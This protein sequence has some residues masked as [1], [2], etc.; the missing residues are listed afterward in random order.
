MKEI[1]RKKI[2]AFLKKNGRKPISY[3]ELISKC[4]AHKQKDIFDDVIAEL[5]GQ[6]FIL[7][8][9]NGYVSVK[10]IG[11]FPA[12]VSRINKTFGFI[13]RSDD[14]TEVFIPG[15]F[16]MAAMP[17]DI[18]IARLIPSRTGKPEGEIVSIVKEQKAR[19]TGVIVED[20]G[21]IAILPDSIVKTPIE[22]VYTRHDDF[23]TGDKVIAEIVKR[24]KRH[25]EHKAKVVTSF[26]SA[27]RAEAC[28]E[29]VLMLNGITKE[30]PSQVL[31]EAVKVSEKGISENEINKRTD[32]R[33]QI[34]FTIDG[35]DTKDIDDAV[36]IKKFEDFYELGVHIADVSYYVKPRSELDKEAF[37][38]GTSV[39]YADKV[40]PMLPK[41]L[42]NGICSLNPNE[43]RLAFSCIMVI[44]MDG[45]L[46]DFDFKKT[47]IRSRVKG[48]YSEINAILNGNENE[49]IKEKYKEVRNNIFIME[50]LAEK[51]TANKIARG[52]PQIETAESKLI[53]DE[54]GICTDVKNRERGKSELIIEEFMLMANTAAAR[55]GKM[56]NIPFVYRIHEEPS[57]EKINDLQE[58]LNRMGVDI[59]QFTKVRPS[60]LAKILEQEKD[61]QMFRVVNKMILRSMAKAKY[62]TEP[63]GHFGLVLNDYAHFTSPIRRYPDLSIHRILSDLVAGFSNDA[64]TKKY[65]AFAFSSAQHSTE[66]ELTAMK[67]ERDCEDC[68]KAEYMMS[69]IGEE[70]TGV[71]SSA[72][73]FGIYVE[74]P[75]TVEGLVHTENMPE[76]T[77]DFDGFVSLKEIRTGKIYRVGDS[78][79]V[80]CVKADVA[81]GNVDFA[82]INQQ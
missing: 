65:E 16:L 48:V 76:G 25:S 2:L 18:V 33:S 13:T 44:G 11:M 10:S 19:F 14:E 6:G 54:N 35:A 1:I 24:G 36:S 37:A 68:Y 8:R 73:D 32:L 81:A 47:V 57:L 12:V 20:F 9:K 41:E 34:I 50:E 39:Y 58:T 46:Q 23:K 82:L 60:H 30:F 40:I 72:T 59:P 79:K 62:S 4:K 64:I 56:Q 49:E 7:E 15:K 78:V 43:D 80:R 26:G 31:D 74:L 3:K 55:L 52:A 53:M 70:F 21:R 51:M 28:A 17:G 5:K 66:T 22:L 77:Y 71:I 42:S 63:V 67:T 29:S 75:N 27:E 69:H 45:K 38:R 61:T